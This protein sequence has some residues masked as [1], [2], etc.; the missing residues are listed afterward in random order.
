LPEDASE[1]QEQQRPIAQPDAP[2]VQL[3]Q[4]QLE[5][6]DQGPRPA[7]L[8]CADAAANAGVGRAHQR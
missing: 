8:S 5:V 4:H 3:L 1:A 6:A 7:V 2:S